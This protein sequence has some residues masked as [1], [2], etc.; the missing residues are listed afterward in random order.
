MARP[1]GRRFSRSVASKTRPARRRPAE[2][3]R[4]TRHPRTARAASAALALALCAVAAIAAH[5]QTTAAKT[6]A[7]AEAF[8]TAFYRRHFAH[9]Q[10]FDLT[11]KRERATA[12]P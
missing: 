9:K 5:A 4:M 2:G 7:T 3:D 11:I 1:L 10:R 8:A 6:G 12:A